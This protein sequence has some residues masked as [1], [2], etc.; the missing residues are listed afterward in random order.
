MS[1]IRNA[2]NELRI[3]FL[4]SDKV[5]KIWKKCCPLSY[6]DF[7]DYM[8]GCEE[9]VYKQ[10]G[11]AYTGAEVIRPLCF[12]LRHSVYLV[13]KQCSGDILME[14]SCVST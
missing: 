8:K 13:Y 14:I 9:D 5:T 12:I 10:I 6:S 4:N 2:H 11:D 1:Q 3:S 7:I